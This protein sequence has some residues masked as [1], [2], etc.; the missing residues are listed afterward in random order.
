[1]KVILEDDG[2]KQYD[3]EYPDGTSTAHILKQAK[4]EF[5]HRMRIVDEPR[6]RAP[7][8]DTAAIEAAGREVAR[9]EAAL[10]REQS[11]SERWRETIES[12]RTEVAG[13]EREITNLKN[14]KRDATSEAANS[15]AKLYAC[16]KSL[17]TERD[18]TAKAVDKCA[19][20]AGELAAVKAK[21][22]RERPTGASIRNIS[23]D[24]NGNLDEADIVF[25]YGKTVH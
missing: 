6:P 17:E 15:A 9:A 24:S 12:L 5:G 2:G 23:R 3:A 19:K 18:R 7:V 13:L 1:M 16:E 8:V 10:S 4:E 14:G 11:K 21:P 22:P 20:L 25:Q